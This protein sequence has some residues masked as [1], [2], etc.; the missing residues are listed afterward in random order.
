MH[1]HSATVH[2]LPAAYPIML[3]A[4]GDIRPAV[5]ELPRT[6]LLLLALGAAACAANLVFG[7]NFMFLVYAEAGN[8]LKWFETAFGDH[9]IGFPVLGAAVILVMYA[10]VLLRGIRK[11]KQNAKKRGR[12][13]ADAVL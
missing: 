11:G 13:S 6:L 4:G 8:P 10:P 3:T 1:I 7:T 9:R 2:I 12:S 5:R